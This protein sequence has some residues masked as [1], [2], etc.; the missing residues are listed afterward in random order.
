MKDDLKE[1]MV[2][3]IAA[4]VEA[5]GAVVRRPV[6]DDRIILLARLGIAA[7][8]GSDGDDL[9]CARRVR[10]GMMGWICYLVSRLKAA[11]KAL[12]EAAEIQ[13]NYWDAEDDKCL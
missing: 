4:D 11:W 9:R 1:R 6:F 13:R 2:R 8:R 5:G 10:G 3:R 12:V 7:G